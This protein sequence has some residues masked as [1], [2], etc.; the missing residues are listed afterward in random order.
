MLGLRGQ[1]LALTSKW[2]HYDT[3][4]V[5]TLLESL[6]ADLSG[7]AELGG[8]EARA[9]AERLLVALEPA[10][11]LTLMQAFSEAAAEISHALE[12]VQVSV[13]LVG[14][15]PVFVVEG[16]AP[17]FPPEAGD[18]EGE[19]AARLTLRLPQPLKERAEALAAERGQSLN[20]WLVGAVRAAAEAP[21]G[22][23]SRSEGRRL[24]GWAR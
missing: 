12:G 19:S 9:A 1:L 23:R 7:A 22:A 17:A 2:C 13:R 21:Q 20:T 8:V 11:R 10:F 16:A 15:E 18:A 3:M 14:R 5:T 4:N 24:R 6:R